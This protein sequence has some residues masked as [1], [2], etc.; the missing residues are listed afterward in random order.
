MGFVKFIGE[1]AGNQFYGCL[2]GG[3]LLTEKDGVSKT[4]E[5]VHI[6][7]NGKFTTGYVNFMKQ[8]MPPYR[9]IFVIV[10]I[11]DANNFIN[12]EN[13][14]FVDKSVEILV[15]SEIRKRLKQSSKII[16]SGVF[17]TH[18]AV[19][20]LGRRQLRKTFLHFWG[21]DFYCLREPGGR[22]KTRIKNILKIYCCKKC[23]GLIFLI[24]GEYDNFFKITHIANAHY[25]APMP[26]NTNR[27]L[28]FA[29][30]RADGTGAEMKKKDSVNVLVGNSATET[31]HHLEVF[32]MLKKFL[33]R[34]IE[35]YVPLSYG[36]AP[37][38]KMI[39]H[40]GRRLL[41]EAFHPIVEYMKYEDYV[42]FLAKMDIG[43]FNNDRQQGMGNI[44]I[45]L[46]LGK[47]VYARDDTSMWKRYVNEGKCIYPLSRMK[48][49]DFDAFI[50][51]DEKDKQKNEMLEDSYDPV[52]ATKEKWS[53]LFGICCEPQYGKE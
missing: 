8:H 44:T 43:V 33:S 16:V 46:A 50:Y 32:E 11:Y 53:F 27:T 18:V 1:D 45:M 38:R 20:F 10:G 26:R 5:I 30:Y 52:K 40:E 48:E 31:N 14:Y 34:K 3:S 29:D 7:A 21:G 37:Y 4:K 12:N 15:K 22:L 39:L 17:N 24:D 13:I 42:A 36:D 9:H 35:V 41:G 19:A 2:Y 25:V 49:S 6:L 28:R 23:A 51:F 47:K